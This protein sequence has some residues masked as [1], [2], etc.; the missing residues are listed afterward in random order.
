VKKS[1]IRLLST[2]YEKTNVI[3]I[4]HFFNQ[5]LKKRHK[6]NPVFKLGF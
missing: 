5:T 1:Q 2:V 4:I 6:K 3:E